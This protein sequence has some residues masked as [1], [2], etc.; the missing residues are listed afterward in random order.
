MCAGGKSPL[1]CCVANRARCDAADRHDMARQK[2][3]DEEV[4]RHERDMLNKT[5]ELTE[6]CKRPDV[7]NAI[8]QL[9][10]HALSAALDADAAVSRCIVALAPVNTAEREARSKAL[11]VVGNLCVDLG[12]DNFT[13][14][15]PNNSISQHSQQ[16]EKLGNEWRQLIDMFRRVESTVNG[17]SVTA[18]HI[19]V[20]V[21][22][23]LQATKHISKTVDSLVTKID[24]MSA[25]PPEVLGAMVT[26]AVGAAFE[27][28]LAGQ[29]A[30]LATVGVSASAAGGIGSHV[31]KGN[32]EV[33]KGNKVLY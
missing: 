24:S 17:I 21:D 20:V 22:E 25:T 30:T 29:G 15:R 10:Q 5:R 7:A 11:H 31:V 23:S 3:W 33:S 26:K 1:V 14:T 28:Y 32:V 4:M 9:R 6:Y 2:M 13:R 27:K 19:K 8:G 12:L 18:E 16:I